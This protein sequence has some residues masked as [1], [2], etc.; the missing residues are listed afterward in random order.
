MRIAAAVLLL[1]IGAA[2]PV[3]AQSVDFGAAVG[4]GMFGGKDGGVQKSTAVPLG[5]AFSL[6]ID[7]GTWLRVGVSTRAPA[8]E[9]DNWA[10]RGAYRLE[11]ILLV[12]LADKTGKTLD[13][14]ASR[15]A[16]GESLR[17]MARSLSLDYDALYEAALID[18]QCVRERTRELGRVSSFESTA[19][20]GGRP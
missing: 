8:G 9:M 2:L 17:G 20:P 12:R 1:I 11:L 10:A 16:K 13:F 19:T 4:P 5:L 15:R 6:C 3:A 7:T 14:L 18:E